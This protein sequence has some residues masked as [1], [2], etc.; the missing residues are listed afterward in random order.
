MEVTLVDIM[1]Q[2]GVTK[3]P[4]LRV[5]VGRVLLLRAVLPFVQPTIGNSVAMLCGEYSQHFPW[6]RYEYTASSFV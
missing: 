2:R 5:D 4:L 1:V 6:K 3:Q